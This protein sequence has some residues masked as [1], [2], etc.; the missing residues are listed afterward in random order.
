MFRKKITAFLL[1]LF[2]MLSLA[3]SVLAISEE[4]MKK[5]M[6]M[7]EQERKFLLM[8]FDEDEL[9]VVSTTRSLK[10]IDRIAENVEVVTYEDIELMNAHTVAEALYNVT[11]IEMLNF[12][13]PGAQG[14][15]AIH[16]SDYVRVAVLLDGV[17]LQNANNAVALGVLPVQ[18]INKIEIIKG[19]ASSTWGSSFGGV[20]NIITKSVE[21]GEHVSG[22]VYASGGEHNTSDVRAE[23]YGRKDNIGLYLY[24]GTMNSDGLRSGREFWHNNFFSKVTLD[25]GEKTKIDFSFLYHK[26]DSEQWDYLGWDNDAYDA[27]VYEYIYGRAALST[28]LSNNLDM[29]ISAWFLKINEGLYENTV[30]TDQRLWAVHSNS[31]KY[32]FSGNITWRTG[33][34]AIVAGTDVSNFEYKLSDSEDAHEQRKYAFFINDTIALNSLTITP[35]LRYD[36]NNLG[37]DIF[38]PSLGIT[39]PVS[40]D[41]LLRALFSRGFHDPVITDF[42]DSPASGYIANQEIE[43]EKIWSYEVGAEANIHDLI[44]TKLTLFLHDIEDVRVDKDLGDGTF[45]AENGGKERTIGGELE[46]IT[47]AYKGFTLTAGFHYEN[48]EL[49][50]FSDVR[51]FD[52]SNVYGINTT[53]T[54]NEGKGLRAMLKGH[55]LW[56][57]APTYWE[58]KYNGFIVDFNIIKD[59]LKKK[60]T[61]LDVFFTAHNIFNAAS[62]ND[63]FVKNP[64]R[65]IE[66]GLRYKF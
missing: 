58:A 6:Q 16:G 3:T 9:F 43:P 14:L 54:Y 32:G 28:A 39:Y 50:D 59:V 51:L 17:P 42:F 8:Y 48:I 25:A 26:S 64:N 53:L 15:A 45:T 4:N 18:M 55:C 11:G 30:S 31:D 49:L 41:L 33:E 2:S 35:G 12:T 56:W 66:A 40:K 19:P 62:Y 23:V 65:W 5:L 34:H 61:N 24:G 38:S 57:N 22:T 47:K 29:N 1:V 20:I 7:S 10:S 27:Y 37:G 60:D 21:A 63:V 36:H 52:V 46:I 44:K 13:G